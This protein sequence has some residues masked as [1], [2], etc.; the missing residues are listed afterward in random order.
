MK[1]GDYEINT[2]H[3]IDLVETKNKLEHN[4]IKC[5]I[6][7]ED[8]QN[9]ASCVRISSEAVLNLLKQDENAKGTYVYLSL[10]RLIISGYI[11]RSTTIEQRLRVIWAVVL[12][13]RLWWSS[14]QDLGAE[15][16]SRRKG[17]SKTK[18][19]IIQNSFITK[20]T[21]WCIELN[22]H[23]LLYLVLLVINRE[24]PIETLNTYLF[25]SQP[26]ENMFRVARALSGPYSSITNFSV[27]SFLRKCEKISIINPMKTHEGQSSSY[28]LQF[29]QHH[30]S[31]KKKY[32]YS[33]KSESRLS[34]T[35]DDIEKSLVMHFDQL[36]NMP[37]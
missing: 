29:P 7:P 35:T 16:G 1:I 22:A 32:D 2:Q 20:S 37:H 33:N 36:R 34:L 17:K 31:D 24:L 28:H 6:N 8:R 15:K 27:K 3:L 12:T 21:F 26:C 5:D 9:Y 10:L 11:E 19:K 13:C 4:L 23:T 30:K 14:I 18:K 25:T